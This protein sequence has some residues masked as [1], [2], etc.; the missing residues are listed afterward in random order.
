MTGS[1]HAEMNLQLHNCPIIVTSW[2]CKKNTTKKQVHKNT[3]Y[4]THECNLFLQKRPLVLLG[5]LF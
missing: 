2:N 5:F 3:E 4:T 1:V